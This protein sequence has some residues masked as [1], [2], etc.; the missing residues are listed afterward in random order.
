MSLSSA[1]EARLAATPVIGLSTK[2]SGDL[3]PLEV[4]LRHKWMIAAFA[5]VVSSLVYGGL[6]FVKPTYEAQTSIRIDMP[7]VH[8]MQENAALMPS[9][10]PSIEVIHTEM[11][12]LN[13]PRL[14]MTAVTQMG[15]QNDRDFQMCPAVGR[16]AQLGSLVRTLRGLPQPAPEP[17]TVSVDYAAKVLLGSYLSFGND[18]ASFIINVDAAAASPEMAA[19][20]ANGYADAFVHWQRDMKV[21]LAD[22][23]NHWLTSDLDQMAQRLVAADAAVESYRQ[24]HHLIGLHVPDAGGAAPGGLDTVSAQRLEQRNQEL[25]VITATLADKQSTLAQVQAA[26]QTGHYDAISPAL[27]TPTVQAAV[28]RQGE[29]ESTLAQLRSTLGPSHPHV[30]AAAAAMAHNQQLVRQEVAK[31]VASLNGE[32][33]ALQ[34]R[35]SAISAQVNALEG[36][37]AGESQ[38]D[39]K[40]QELTRE[41]QTERTIYESLY[42][43]LKQ[44][45]AER[46][47]EGANTAVV[48]EATPPDVPTYPRKT[49][50]VAGAFLAS[51]GIGTGAA[52]TREMM[53]RRFRDAE[54]IELEI[55][56]PV[57]GLFP[58]HSHKPQDIIVESPLSVEAEAIHATLTRIMDKPSRGDARTGVVALVT[59]ALPDEGKSSFSVALARCAGRRAIGRLGASNR[60]EQHRRQ[61]SRYRQRLRHD[62]N[63]RAG[64]K[65][66][67]DGCRCRWIDGSYRAD[68]AVPANRAGWRAGCFNRKPAVLR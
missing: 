27:T 23:A 40:L 56:L 28:D 67:A 12:V 51:L 17:C 8:L 61:H 10:Q 57:L 47:L 22:D 4:A 1:A 65:Q 53:S 39:V 20:L 59:S 68:Q 35:K 33:T 50:M 60:L 15:L 3:T 14:A 31:T 36:D 29:L 66:H 9:E 38:A 45:D 37:V 42:V 21:S 58:K 6:R 48:V 49:M 46:R 52:F 55:G 34:A 5:L 30:M 11:A 43:R 62:D 16:L 44:I 32:V 19:R 7:E 54:Q 41:A 64:A 13:S 24:N 25:N 26:M 2:S 18:R 63:R